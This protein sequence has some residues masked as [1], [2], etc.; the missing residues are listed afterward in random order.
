MGSGP[1]RVE[2]TGIVDPLVH[3]PAVDP[4]PG[5]REAAE[6]VV[7][8]DGVDVRE[9]PA[10]GLFGRGRVIAGCAGMTRTG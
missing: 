4:E 6:D 9:R 10:A 7:G 1:A 2:V 8:L 5:A 3:L